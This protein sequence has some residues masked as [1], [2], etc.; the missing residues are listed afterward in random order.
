MTVSLA[1]LCALLLPQVACTALQPVRTAFPDA[2]TPHCTPP[3]TLDAAQQAPAACT[4]LALERADHYAMHV[5]EFDDQGQYYTADNPDFGQAWNQGNAFVQDVRD[6]LGN[7]PQ[8]G[9]SVLVFIHGWRHS[10]VYDDPH[11]VQFRSML[12]QLASVEGNTCGRK[13]IGLYVGWRG[14]A[15][16]AGDALESLSF[17][18]RKRAAEN[19]GAGQLQD[20][21]GT[22]RAIQD[23]TARGNRRHN[24]IDCSARVKTTYIGHSFGGLALLTAMSQPLMRELAEERERALSTNPALQSVATPPADE[25]VVA[26]NPAMEGARFN[27][28][29]ELARQIKSKRYRPPRLVAITSR[30][31]AAT[32]V[33]FRYGRLLGTLA[34]RYP[35]GTPQARTSSRVAV[36]HDPHYLTHELISLERPS[37]PASAYDGFNCDNAAT[38]APSTQSPA[39]QVAAA[40]EKRQSINLRGLPRCLPVHTVH[41]GSDYVN[42]VLGPYKEADAAPGVDD[43][44]YSPVWNVSTRAP[45]V[46]DHNDFT[47]QRLLDFLGLLYLESMTPTD[48]PTGEFYSDRP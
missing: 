5:V 26:I 33:A 38:L 37:V 13:V 46:D 16:R 40:P 32:R 41:G 20:V 30:D 45:V 29:F 17:W 42:L 27:A 24:R 14:R 34:E 48:V 15:G 3:E 35:E 6:T 36:G 9:V 12:A 28:L 39:A 8:V 43:A 2:S 19:L 10:A 4:H 11:L 7:D 1:A 31:D 18:S 25:L 23:T 44:S 47:N 22:L 21:L